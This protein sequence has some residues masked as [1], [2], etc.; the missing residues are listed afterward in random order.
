MELRDRVFG[1]G[2]EGGG[3]V[4]VVV[5]I[6]RGAATFGVSL[7][8]STVIVGVLRNVSLVRNGAGAG[9]TCDFSDRE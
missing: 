6:C 8:C 5:L 1:P 9:G 4:H 7:L 3:V 2:E